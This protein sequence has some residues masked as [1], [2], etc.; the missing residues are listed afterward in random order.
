MI[1]RTDH[2]AVAR[3]RWLREVQTETSIRTLN[4]SELLTIFG[5]STKLGNR[6]VEQINKLCS[7]DLSFAD[8][9]RVL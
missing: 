1:F 5:V 3:H 6:D 4:F 9:V 7:K 2:K 8:P